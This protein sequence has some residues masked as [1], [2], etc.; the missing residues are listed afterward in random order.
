MWV[1]T[2]KTFPSCSCIIESN[3]GKCS[4]IYRKFPLLAG[5]DLSCF[6]REGKFWLQLHSWYFLEWSSLISWFDEHGKILH[7]DLSVFYC[8]SLLFVVDNKEVFSIV[9]LSVKASVSV[10]FTTSVLSSGYRCWGFGRK[11][12]SNVHACSANTDSFSNFRW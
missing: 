1:C 3:K 7:V 10:S 6:P 12:S 4:T 2:F 8:C 5:N 9:H 11:Y